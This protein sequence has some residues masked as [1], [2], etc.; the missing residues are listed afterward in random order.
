MKKL[1]VNFAL[2]KNIDIL[3]RLQSRIINDIVDLNCPQQTKI[4]ANLFQFHYFIFQEI[5]FKNCI[6]NVRNVH[7]A[8][9]E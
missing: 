6:S 2:L 3:K 5:F 1:P 4:S 9:R 7:V 8:T